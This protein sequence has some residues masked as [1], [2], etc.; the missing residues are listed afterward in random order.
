MRYFVVMCCLWVASVAL[1]DTLV[2]RLAHHGLKPPTFDEVHRQYLGLA[3]NESGLRSVPDQDGIFQ[4]LSR[5]AR[6]PDSSIDITKLMI[7]MMLNSPRT[8]PIDSPWRA[9]YQRKKKLKFLDKHRTPRNA[10]SIQLDL[11]CQR[12]E[13]WPYKT[14]DV[15]RCFAMVDS[16]RDLLLGKTKTRCTNKGRVSTWGSSEDVLKRKIKELGWLEVTCD[17]VGPMV[18]GNTLDCD[19]LR[20][21]AAKSKEGR[22]QLSNTPECAKNLFYYWGM[23]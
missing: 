14:W 1:A 8:F 7:Q 11:T 12:P 16:T 10:W 22:R 13:A 4:S 19:A 5:R 21:E 15:A 6:N 23:P 20:G 9:V 18:P 17:R 2:E 3:A